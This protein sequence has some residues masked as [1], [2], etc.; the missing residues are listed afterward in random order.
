MFW[1]WIISDYHDPLIEYLLSQ[2]FEVTDMIPPEWLM[3]NG[4]IILIVAVL[5]FIEKRMTLWYSNKEWCEMSCWP[6]NTGLL[7]PWALQWRHASR[8]CNGAQITFI[9]ID[10][11][12]TWSGWHK[13]HRFLAFS[14]CNWAPF[15]LRNGPTMLKKLSIADFAIVAKDGLF[16]LATVTSRQLICDVTRTW[17]TGIVTSY[18]SIA[19]WRKGD[20]H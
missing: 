16:W 15:N 6:G 14:S 10:C 17:C 2:H 5:W 9:S 12:R 11:T 7:I 18:S 13:E 8:K 3:I 20:P 4:V 19:N 1:P